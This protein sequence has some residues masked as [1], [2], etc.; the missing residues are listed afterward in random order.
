M[1]KWPMVRLGDVCEFVNGGTPSKKVQQFYSGTIPWITSA[2][3][4][5]DEVKNA[6]CFITEEAINNS[7]TKLV[8]KGTILLV[9]RTGVGKVA[10]TGMDLC[11]SQDITGVLPD[12]SKLNKKYLAYFLKSNINYFVYLQRGATI[13][14]ITRNVVESLEITLSPLNIQKHIAD[15]LDKT[16]EIINGHKKQLAELDNLIKA[17]FYEMFGDPITN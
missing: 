9:T 5:S 17:I 14:G 4:V 2:D 11:F 6:R 16:Q 15:T 10:I 12:I 1:S 3:I 8:K 7:T 13:Q